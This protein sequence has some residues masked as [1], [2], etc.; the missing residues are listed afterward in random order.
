MLALQDQLHHQLRRGPRSAFPLRGRVPFGN[1]FH[2]TTGAAPG[3]VLARSWHP[4]PAPLRLSDP[5]GSTDLAFWPTHRQALVVRVAKQAGSSSAQG[6]QKVQ[7]S[8]EIL[9]AASV[10]DWPA[11]RGS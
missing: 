6:S 7:H 11:G 2:L 1:P 8:W 4:A 10:Q 9:Q 5:S 3:P